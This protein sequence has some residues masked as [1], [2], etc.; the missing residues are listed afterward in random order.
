[1]TIAIMALQGAFAEHEQMLRS[2]GVDTFLIRNTEDWQ[3]HKDALILPGGE[4]TAHC[5]N[6]HSG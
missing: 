5:H 4:S 2:L 1:M 3:R 6:G